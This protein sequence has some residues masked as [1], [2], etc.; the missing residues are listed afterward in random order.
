MLAPPRQP[1]P[2][3]L[4]PPPPPEQLAPAQ[5]GNTQLNEASL[6]PAA[7]ALGI[8]VAQHDS[9]PLPQNA[10]MPKPA[11]GAAAAPFG[12]P[13]PQ[14]LGSLELLFWLLVAAA[15]P[16]FAALLGV[17]AR[18]LEVGDGYVLKAGAGFGLA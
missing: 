4:L 7:V 17:L 10:R 11:T 3:P 2:L 13:Q 18:Y 5:P 6:P 9:N 14:Q 8:C 1:L 15:P 12:T 16:I